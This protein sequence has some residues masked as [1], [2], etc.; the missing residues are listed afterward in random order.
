LTPSADANQAGLN[1]GVAPEPGGNE[2]LTAS[3]QVRILNRV[4]DIPSFGKKLKESGK[5]GLVAGAIE[6]FQINVGKLCN[7]SCKHCHVDSGPDKIR[8]NMDRETLEK[9]LAIIRNTPTIKTV[10]VTGGA[11]E[12][13]PHLAWFIEA[14]SA[15]GKRFIVRSNLS[16]L[17]SSKF[18][19]FIDLFVKHGVEVVASLPDFEEAKSD[20]Q[21]GK[22]SFRQII[23]VMRLLNE[24]GYGKEGTGLLLNLVHNPVGAYLPG[25]QAVLEAAYKKRLALDHGVF[26][27]DLYAITNMPISRYLE[28]LLETENFEEYMEALVNAYNPATVDGLMCRNTLSVSWDGQL[29]DCDFNQMLELPVNHGAPKT[30][31]D[32]DLEKLENRRIV[33]HNGCFGCT[34]GAGSSCQGTLTH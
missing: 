12:M 34:A 29:F 13:N 28:Y 16:I 1:T 4:E 32:F 23:K 2:R 24:K 6:I 14:V 3:A 10:D 20:R 7:L 5:R 8:E 27:N 11:P 18:C 33:I 9:C 25:P 31:D 21:R 15:L 22:G 19:H 26:F 30:L 17:M